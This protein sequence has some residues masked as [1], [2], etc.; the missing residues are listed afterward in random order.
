MNITKKTL[1]NSIWFAAE[2]IGIFVLIQL[3]RIV[4]GNLDAVYSGL[5]MVIIAGILF[6][7]AYMVAKNKDDNHSKNQGSKTFSNTFS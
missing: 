2:V 1:L 4:I 3:I 6:L 7:A 5:I